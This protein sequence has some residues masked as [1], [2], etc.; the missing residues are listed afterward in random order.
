MGTVPL[1]GEPHQAAPPAS[2]HCPSPQQLG[3][4]RVSAAGR[5]DTAGSPLSPY[6]AHD[7]ALGTIVTN[8]ILCLL[9]RAACRMAQ[10][11]G[12]EVPCCWEARASSH[13]LPGTAPAGTTPERLH[14]SYSPLNCLDCPPGSSHASSNLTPTEPQNTAMERTAS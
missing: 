1:A 9:R 13:L 4:R 3:S 11:M 14:L 7:G 12:G 8:V 6:S 10:L 2:A 5:Q